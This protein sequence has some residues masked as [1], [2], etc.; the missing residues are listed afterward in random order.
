M[1]KN[2]I[3]EKTQLQGKLC[4]TVYKNKVPIE[5]FSDCNLIMDAIRS[6][7]LHIFAG[8]LLGDAASDI[9]GLS[10]NRIAFG[11][12]GGDINA[13]CAEITTPFFKDVK[14]FDYPNKYQVRFF[15]ELLEH[16]ANG[17]A[18]NEFGLITNDGSL[19][20]R[21][22]R[23]EPLQ[24]EGDIAIEGEWIISI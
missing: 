22:T 3:A 11:T 8:D 24:K 7:C 19:F 1:G 20:S 9:E 10:I 13:D 23:E 18:I 4:Y 15:W 16:E 14:R 21:R 17:M 2:I 12:S 6:K 5:R